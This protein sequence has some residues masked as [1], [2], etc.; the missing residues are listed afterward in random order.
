M[1]KYPAANNT[2]AF[3]KPVILLVSMWHTDMCVERVGGLEL[4]VTIPACQGFKRWGYWL[5][6]KDSIVHKK[7]C[8]YRNTKMRKKQL[9]SQKRWLG[10]KTTVLQLINYHSIRG[11]YTKIGVIYQTYIQFKFCYVAMMTYYY[12]IKKVA[13]LLD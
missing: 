8:K 1:W 12:S 3:L 2:W 6:N 9:R 13:V 10:C 5:S 4:F 11:I 7:C